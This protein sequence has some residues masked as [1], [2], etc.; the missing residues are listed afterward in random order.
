MEDLFY[1][2]TFPDKREP[3]SFCKRNYFIVQLI[4]DNA[5]VKFIINEVKV[6]MAKSRITLQGVKKSFGAQDSLIDVLSGIDVHFEQGN[7]YAITGV[8]GTGKSTL[9]HIIAGIDEPTNGMVFFDGKTLKELRKKSSCFLGNFIGLVFQAP[10][11][12]PELSVEE[13]VMMPALIA[14]TKDKIAKEKARFLLEKVGLEQKCN[15]NPFSL[16]GGQQQRVAVVRAV[17]NEPAFLLA[18]EPTGNLDS[19]TGKYIVDLLLACQGQWGMGIVV[20]SHDAYVAK[21]MR[22]CFELHGGRLHSV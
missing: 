6:F 17:M 13:N 10:Y 2:T 19:K 12:I 4:I 16:S 20:T 8:S 3:N 11:L 14:G 15:A 18:D 22:N 7:S 21:N 1:K 5:V 9:M